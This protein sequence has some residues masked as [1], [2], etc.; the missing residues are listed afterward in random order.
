M[1]KYE[2]FD[3]CAM[4]IVLTMISNIIINEILI[5]LKEKKK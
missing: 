3:L 4:L 1:V 2:N 5:F